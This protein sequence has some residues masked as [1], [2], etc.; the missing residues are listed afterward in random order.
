MYHVKIEIYE[1]GETPKAWAELLHEDGRKIE[2]LELVGLSWPGTK[3][4]EPFSHSDIMEFAVM[5]C[6]E[7]AQKIDVPLF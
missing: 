2:K 7:L 6:Q 1:Q 3:P 4:P 5:V